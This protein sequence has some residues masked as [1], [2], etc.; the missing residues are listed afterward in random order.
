M[1]S[2]SLDKRTNPAP[3]IAVLLGSAMLAVGG[4]EYVAKGSSVGGLLM[5]PGALFFVLGLAAI[6]GLKL[7]PEKSKPN[8]SWITND[9]LH[10][11]ETDEPVW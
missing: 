9:G 4:F 7:P 11:E 1:T 10:D 8:G 5:L 6:P 2:E 3:Y